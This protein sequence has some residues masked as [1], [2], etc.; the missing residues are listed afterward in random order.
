MNT[1]PLGHNNPPADKSEIQ[2]A[3]LKQKQATPISN[4]Q[5]LLDAV[6]RAPQ[7]IVT[8]DEAEKITA[9]TKL[10][11]DN[12]KA[13][14]AA[15]QSEKEP[16]L[17]GGRVVD[18]FFKKFI[19]D[20]EAAKKNINKPLTAWLEKKAAEERQRIAEEAKR[21]REQA[22]REL[23]AAAQLE[24]AG[25]Q[26]FAESAVAQAGITEQ[27]AAKLVTQAAAKPAHLAS[28]R[29]TSGTG[30]LRTRW[31]GEV[32]DRG[33][34]DLEALRAHL[35]ADAMQKALNAFIAAGGRELK[36]ARIFEE[37]SAVVR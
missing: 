8:E 13:L 24:Q 27:A 22:Q 4:T 25:H 34:I 30:A 16:Y 31:V 9:L 26:Q 32:L 11:T 5:R 2:L 28:V 7:V 10:L 19:D 15:R 23:E 21:V 37:S 3:E 35:P 14:E 36:G 6:S 17:T 29:S 20:T 18:N 1:A 33:V 12:I